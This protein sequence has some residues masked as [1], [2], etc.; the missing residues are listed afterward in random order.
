MSENRLSARNAA[1][2][3]MLTDGEKIHNF[4]RFVAQNPH[5][6]LRDA[7]QIIISRPNASVCFSFDEWNAMG[8]RV[9]RGKK[10]VPYY[11]TD[12]HKHFVFDANDTKSYFVFR[13][14]VVP[15]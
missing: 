12:G 13:N 3:E 7:C 10:G 6:S 1:I 2:Q 14:E 8:R 11:D 4:Y 5:I 15:C 9:T